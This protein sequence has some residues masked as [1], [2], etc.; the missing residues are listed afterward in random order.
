MGPV[1]TKDPASLLMVCLDL[2]NFAAVIEVL[3]LSPGY[4]VYPST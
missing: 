4:R 1:L 3:L 2:A